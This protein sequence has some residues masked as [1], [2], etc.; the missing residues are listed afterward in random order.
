MLQSTSHN[1]TTTFK[2]ASLLKAALLPKRINVTRLLLDINF[3]LEKTNN[4]ALD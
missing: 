4:L 1:F 3:Y 2:M